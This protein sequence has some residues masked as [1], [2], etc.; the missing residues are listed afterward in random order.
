MPSLYDQHL[1]LPKASAQLVTSNIVK[2]LRNE[3][4][5][6]NIKKAILGVSGGIDS[7]LSLVLAVKALGPEN[8]YGILMPYKTSHPDS[9]AH[10][11]EL[12]D[13]FGVSYQEQEITPM[14]DAWFTKNTRISKLRM[15][16]V[17]ARLRMIV[18]YDKSAEL[19]AL[20]IGTSNKT[21]SLVGYSTL[22][23]D[24][25]SAVN[26]LGDL[27]KFQVQE[28]SAFLGVP[29]SILNKPPSADLWEGQTDE[30]ELKI[31]YNILDRILYFLYDMAMPIEQVVE[32]AGKADIAKS[33][34]IEIARRVSRSQFKRKMPV[35]VKVSGRTINREFR[36]PRDWGL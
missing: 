8:V 16:N 13:K 14:A 10:A 30:D 19:D 2:I 12:C 29:Q 35:I 21:E 28:L 22:W 33:V 4:L 23:G 25:A 20:V 18:L 11:I 1:P 3:I 17:M 34:V 26:P 15:G 27:Y 6:T 36:Y 31:S 5:K 32:L 24:M 7:A 9:R